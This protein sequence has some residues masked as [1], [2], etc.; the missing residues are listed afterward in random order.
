[1]SIMCID[2]WSYVMSFL[3]FFMIFLHGLFCCLSKGAHPK[4]KLTSL[5]MTLRGE[6]V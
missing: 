4:K 2:A 1:M 6:G 5:C 3:V